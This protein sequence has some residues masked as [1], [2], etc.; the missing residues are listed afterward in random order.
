M[1]TERLSIAL[2]AVNLGLLAFLAAKAGIAAADG[3][4]AVL[5]GSGIE[6][7]DATGKLRASLTIEP[8]TTAAAGR[9]Y[10]ETVLLRLID[11]AGQPSVK[12]STSGAASGLSL[13]GGDDESYV[14]L[15]ADG[16]DSSLKLTGQG[17]KE[18]LVTP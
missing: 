3:A 4:P 7:V 5:R 13:V 17:G 15:Q 8:A 18:R 11:A 12:I 10:P 9:A 2:T 14:V 1:K 16:S 6:I